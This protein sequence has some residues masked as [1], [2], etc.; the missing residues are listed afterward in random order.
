MSFLTGNNIIQ[1]IVLSSRRQKIS[2]LTNTSF[3]QHALHTSNINLELRIKTSKLK[4]YTFPHK[5]KPYSIP[6]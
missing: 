6:W 2:L 5:H 3:H 1:S 4:L